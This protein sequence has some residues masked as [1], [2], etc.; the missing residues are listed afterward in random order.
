MNTKFNL[1]KAI[2]TIGIFV[3][4]FQVNAQET[5]IKTNELPK[6]AQDFI[7]KNFAGQKVS[8]AVKDKGMIS[9]D[10][11]VWLDNGTKI[12]FDGDGNWEDV[13]S[14]NKTAIPTG[15]IPAKIR[16]YV[17]K[18]F[19]TQKIGKI[20]RSSSKFEVELTNG[21]DLEFNS[22]GEFLRIDD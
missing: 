7:S 19:P 17:S 1:A 3:L 11:E 18:N 20:E 10:Y 2:F 12:E 5:V 14:E 15:F 8:Q 9:T 6:T 21:M 22:Q 16:S 4:S 13:D